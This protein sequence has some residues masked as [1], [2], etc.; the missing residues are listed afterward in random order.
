MT[1][2]LFRKA[3]LDHQRDNI[4]GNILLTN[5]FKFKAITAVFCVITLLVLCFLFFGQY[6]RKENVRGHLVPDQGIVEVL[7]KS[8][9]TI[10]TSHVQDGDQVHAGDLLFTISTETYTHDNQILNDEIKHELQNRLQNTQLRINNERQLFAT[11]SNKYQNKIKTTEAELVKIKQQSIT[12]KKLLDLSEKQLLEHQQHYA[13]KLV[14]AAAVEEKNMAFLNAKSSYENIQ[15]V[16]LNKQ[17]ELD[18]YQRKMESL[19]QE[20]AI[21]LLSLEDTISQIKQ[22]LAETQSAQSHVI[23]APISGQVSTIIAKPGQTVA[24]NGTLLTILP[25]DYVLHAELY[26]PSKSMGFV[27]EGNQVLLRYDAFPYQRYGLYE[28][29]VFEV[30]A[31]TTKSNHIPLNNNE[32]VYQVKVKLANQQVNAFGQDIT[33]QPGMLVSAS[34][35]VEHRSMVEWLLEPILSLRGS[36]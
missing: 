31:T 6:A 22:G 3:A 10:K 21:R 20:K 18:D 27:G 2:T 5:P 29:E 4:Y 26:L 19:P 9:G 32:P 17:N 35:I 34:I 11:E 36:L 24:N 30:A 16:I 8:T 23:R 12:A 1:D 25:N 33:L 13:K 7:A 14:L 15:R 28:G